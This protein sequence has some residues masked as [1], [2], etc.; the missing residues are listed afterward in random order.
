MKLKITGIKPKG[1]ER[2]EAVWL[3][4]ERDCDL[5]D[6]MIADSTYDA[7]GASNLHRH[8]YWFPERAAKKGDRVVLYTKTGKNGVSTTTLGA[9]LHKFFWNLEVAVWNDEGD[10]A[11]LIEIADVQTFAVKPVKA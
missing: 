9:P 2:G 8:T 5:S 4:V 7:E 6:Y 11:V 10:G 1:D 3:A